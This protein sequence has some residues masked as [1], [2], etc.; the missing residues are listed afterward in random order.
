MLTRLVT[1]RTE[2]D[3]CIR[4]HT[5]CVCMCV[6]AGPAGEAEI[7]KRRPT[8][9]RDVIESSPVGSDPRALLSS[10]TGAEVR[11]RSRFNEDP[12]LTYIFLQI[13]KYSKFPRV[14]RVH[15][16]AT[17][18]TRRRSARY[19]VIPS[20]PPT[21]TLKIFAPV[22]IVCMLN[23]DDG[24]LKETSALKLERTELFAN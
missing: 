12:T 10:S 16:I 2:W 3:R 5:V 7:P 4:I 23:P 6:F 13:H 9:S 15:T 21:T 8:R 24:T 11:A 1:V 22:A 19:N 14:S 18:I 20:C 17:T